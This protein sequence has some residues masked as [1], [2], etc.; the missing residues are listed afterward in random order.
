MVGSEYGATPMRDHAY[1]A[2]KAI[3]EYFAWEQE[4]S[5][6]EK[7]REGLAYGVEHGII[8]VDEEQMCMSYF[9]RTHPHPGEIG[10]VIAQP[11]IDVLEA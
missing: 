2:T 1:E 6:E 5:E 4:T 8:T 10:G 3:A 9:M 7:L 11:S